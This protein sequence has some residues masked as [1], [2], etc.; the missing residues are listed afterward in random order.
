MASNNNPLLAGK[1][2]V[3]NCRGLT[4]WDLHTSHSESQLNEALYENLLERQ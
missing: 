3:G 1:G 2:D 4:A